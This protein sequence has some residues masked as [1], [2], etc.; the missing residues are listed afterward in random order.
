MGTVPERRRELLALVGPADLQ[1]LRALGEVGE[2]LL[3]P[4]D[5]LLHQRIAGQRELGPLRQL[6]GVTATFAA[7]AAGVAQRLRSSCC[8]AASALVRAGDRRATRSSIRL[9]AA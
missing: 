5:R 4:V 2:V 3:A 8:A 7:N 6:L 1:V 9:P